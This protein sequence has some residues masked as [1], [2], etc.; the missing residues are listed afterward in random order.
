MRT[1]P[2]QSCTFRRRPR[3]RKKRGSKQLE[4]CRD[5]ASKTRQSQPSNTPV[6]PLKT[7]TVRTWTS[8][9]PGRADSV[10]RSS[11]RSF[12]LLPHA[13]LPHMAL[14]PGR[15]CGKCLD[16]ARLHH[17][18]E[19]ETWKQGMDRIR[20]VLTVRL[21]LVPQLELGEIC[22][23][24]E[25]ARRHYGCVHAVVCGSKLANRGIT[26]EPR[27]LTASQCRPAD[28]FHRQCCLPTQCGPGCVCVWPPP[29]LRQLAETPHRRHLIANCLTTGMKP[30]T[31][32]TRAFTIDLLS[33]LPSLEHCSMQQT[34]SR[35]GQQI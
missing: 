7:K 25:A 23:T 29:L 14:P 28:L 1:K 24:A 10:R 35:N 32:V 3:Q 21:L 31:C 11:K 19:E 4:G 18:R 15:V 34:S 8:Q 22:S 9:R 5:P 30:Q 2:R 20:E 13:C 16:T 27:G 26:T 17:Q 33:G 6:P 12:T